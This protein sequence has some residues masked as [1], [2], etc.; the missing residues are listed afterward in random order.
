MAVC[1]YYGLQQVCYQSLQ[2]YSDKLVMHNKVCEQLRIMMDVSDQ[3]ATMWKQQMV[4]VEKKI[5]AEHHAISFICGANQ[6]KY[7]MLINATKNDIL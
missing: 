6:D 3:G 7:G 5:I 4:E 1:D 2:D